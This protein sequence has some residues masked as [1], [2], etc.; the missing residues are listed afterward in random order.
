MD[1]CTYIF[2]LYATVDPCYEFVDENISWMS[3]TH[4]EDRSEPEPS[5]QQEIG[6]GVNTASADLMYKSSRFRHYEITLSFS[7]EFWGQEGR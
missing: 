6:G 4:V 1:W 5:D 7:A 2:K 3:K